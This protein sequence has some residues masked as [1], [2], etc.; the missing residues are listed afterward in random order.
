MSVDYEQLVLEKSPTAPKGNSCVFIKIG[1][2]LG[3][4]VYRSGWLR[5]TSFNNQK[6]CF[7][8]GLAPEVGECIKINNDYYGY[9]TEV[10]RVISKITNDN[11]INQ[12]RHRRVLLKYETQMREVRAII[13]DKTDFNFGDWHWSF[14]WGIKSGQLM[15]IDFGM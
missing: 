5:D 1:K 7:A 13:R 2:K 6:K 12:R 3:L 15:P 9:V 14:N 10:I 8:I 4:K 11:D